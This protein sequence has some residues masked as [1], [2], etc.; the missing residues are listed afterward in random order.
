MTYAGSKQVKII[1]ANSPEEFE[2]KLNREL[3]IL[4]KSRT[5]Y[6]LQFN[7]NLGLCAYIVS[8]RTVEIPENIIDE[9]G[10]IGERH[11]CGECPFWEKPTRGNVK[12]TRCSK[13][14]GIHAK[15][16]SCCERFYE[17]LLSGEI[18]IEGEEGSE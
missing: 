12:Y 11:T 17:M 14:P 1:M 8:E 6:D 13:T 3:A 16:S 9:F 2:K 15:H 4:D 10:L 7:H 5:K 18:V